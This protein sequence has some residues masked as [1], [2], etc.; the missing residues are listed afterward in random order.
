[1]R[2]VDARELLSA[3][4]D[5]ELPPDERGAVIKHLEQCE[6]CSSEALA[7]RGLKHAVARI[8]A[9]EMPP[10]AVRAHIDAL[11]FAQNPRGS[12]SFAVAAALMFLV[13][14]VAVILSGRWHQDLSDVVAADHLKSNPA[15]TP[16]HV[17]TRSPAAIERFFAG[18][19][20]FEPTVPRLD[21]AEVLGARVCH[22]DGQT[23]ELIFYRHNGRNISLFVTAVP[24]STAA[25]TNRRGLTVCREERNGLGIYAVSDLPDTSLRR[26]LGHS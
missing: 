9:E 17:V 21:G 10:A 18:T 20:R 16:P 6:H 13:V 25:C 26:L 24:P 22:L 11:R 7:L 5:D 23:A 15:V 12:R 4:L 2:C 1:M 8:Q 14:L 3:V 19:T